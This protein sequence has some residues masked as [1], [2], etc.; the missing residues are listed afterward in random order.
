VKL[1]S[2]ADDMEAL[3]DQP[4]PFALITATHLMTQASN[5][6]PDKR[7]DLK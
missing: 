7:F 1:K 5:H 2:L 6:D 4:N 3:L